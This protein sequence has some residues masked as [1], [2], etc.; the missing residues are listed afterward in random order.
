MATYYKIDGLVMEV[1]PKN[2]KNFTYDELR[3]FVGYI[4]QIVPLPSGKSIVVHEEGKNINLPKN[5][6]ATE[7]WVKEYP[8]EKYPDNNDMLIAGDALIATEKELGDE[9]DEPEQKRT[10]I[11]PE[12]AILKHC[13]T[14]GRE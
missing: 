3:A 14:C 7:E 10:H 2:G 12:G 4:V 5:N 11:G 13:V 6:R 8:I 1:T 9:E